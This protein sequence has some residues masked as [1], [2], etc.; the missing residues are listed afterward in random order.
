[1]ALAKLPPRLTPYRFL[2]IGT[3][4]FVYEINSSVVLKYPR[5]QKDECFSREIEIY[6]IF[7]RYSPCPDIVQSFLRVPEG[8]FLAY[9]SGG[10]LEQRVRGRPKDKEVSVAVAERW[11][12]ELSNA[13]AWLESLGYI[14]GDIRPPNIM[15]DDDDHLKL[16]DFDSLTEIGTRYDGAAPPWARLLEDGTFGY[17]GAK[18]EQFAIGSVLYFATRGYEPYEAEDLGEDYG[19]KVVDLQKMEF[20][21]L[22]EGHLDQIIETCWNGQFST[23]EE[24][25]EKTKLLRGANE[26][27]RATPLEKEYRA[28]IQRECLR[29]VESGLLA[30]E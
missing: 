19:P 26:L 16:T 7:E 10:T 5:D 17:C 8:N 14:H 29:L 4:G 12:M 24:L 15:F 1:M 11:A 6:D 20:P 30:M 3:V 2:S 27:P 28:E 23:L 9:L 21:G 18:T 13:V 22:G 25:A